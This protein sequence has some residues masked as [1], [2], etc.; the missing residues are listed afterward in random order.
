MKKTT[1]WMVMGLLCL[2]AAAMVFGAQ[3]GKAPANTISWKRCL[4][5]RGEFYSGDEAIRIADN[6]LLYQRE[7]GGWLKGIDMAAILS[8][9]DKAELLRDKNKGNSTI[10]NGA[11]H[12]QIRYLAKV[13]IAT[14]LER[15]SVVSHVKWQQFA[16][17]GSSNGHLESEKKVK[18]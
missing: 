12:T 7:N 6:V 2:F 15:I 16:E 1:H 9:E 3:G 4:S 17:D 18:F 13:Y 8:E 11:T 5:Q 14:G 10:D